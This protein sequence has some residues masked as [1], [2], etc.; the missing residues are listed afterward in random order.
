MVTWLTPNKKQE[1][2]RDIY[3]DCRE[4]REWTQTAFQLLK[5]SFYVYI[6]GEITYNATNEI[7]TPCAV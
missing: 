2:T 4:N 1:I 3:Q 7:S 5:G 6:L